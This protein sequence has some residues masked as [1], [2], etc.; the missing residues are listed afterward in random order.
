MP[1]KEH[2]IGTEQGR[3][4]KAYEYVREVK[5]LGL[6]K[7]RYKSYVKKVPS[8]IKINGLGNT[9]AFIKSKSEREYQQI[10]DQTC[11]WITE[12]DPKDLLNLKG[13]GIGDMEFVEKLV[14]IDSNSYRAVTGEILAL[15]NW[16]RR[17]AGTL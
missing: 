8:Y 4:K 3:A 11:R 12:D 7:G 13:G 16:M 9:F 5:K 1:G 17:F 14:N 15:F 6:D 2:M 10:Y